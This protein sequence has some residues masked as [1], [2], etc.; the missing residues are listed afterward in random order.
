MRA[1]IS[2]SNGMTL[3]FQCEALLKEY[4]DN[5]ELLKI[6]TYK[7]IRDKHGIFAGNQNKFVESRSDLNKRDPMTMENLYDKY[8]DTE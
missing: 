8:Y 6:Q 4:N 2:D 3:V 5:L 1:T 7:K